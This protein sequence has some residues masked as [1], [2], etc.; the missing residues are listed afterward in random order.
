MDIMRENKHLTLKGVK[1]IV[2]IKTSFN[3][4]LSDN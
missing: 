2:A 3:K 1:D 4:G